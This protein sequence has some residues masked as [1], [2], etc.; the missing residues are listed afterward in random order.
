MRSVAALVVVVAAWAACAHKPAVNTDEGQ[1]FDCRARSVGYIATH[2]LGAAEIGVEMSCAGGPQLKHWR[3]DDKTSQRD[4]K[5]RPMTPAEFD[6]VWSQIAG[7]GWEY[8]KDCRNGDGGKSIYQF[9]VKDDQNTSSFSCETLRLPY[10][11]ND[12][13]DPLDAAVQ[14]PAE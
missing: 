10:P 9:M 5:S 11:Y 14:A 2:T 3:V 1:A 4:E 13:A 8:L 7:T 12:L 6:H